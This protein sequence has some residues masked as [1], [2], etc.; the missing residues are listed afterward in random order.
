MTEPEFLNRINEI[1]RKKIKDDRGF[2][3]AAYRKYLS[4]SNP[5]VHGYS[6][7]FYSTEKREKS[8][9]IPFPS[10]WIKM[11][12]SMVMVRKFAKLLAS[13][14]HAREFREKYLKSLESPAWWE[15]E[16]SIMVLDFGGVSTLAPDWANEVFCYYGFLQKRFSTKSN[17]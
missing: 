13:R 17:W 7:P 1:R 5:L 15:C 9:H 12:K 11:N 6:V 3:I 10:D 14:D 4:S 8:H 16:H 2:L